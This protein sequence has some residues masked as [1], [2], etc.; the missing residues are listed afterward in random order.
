VAT[1]VSRYTREAEAALV[2]DDRADQRYLNDVRD[3][4]RLLGVAEADVQNL[5][6]EF[7]G[8]LRRKGL[9]AQQAVAED[10]CL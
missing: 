3:Y 1:S 4:L 2:S 10:A 7:Y 5:D 6:R 9:T 8:M